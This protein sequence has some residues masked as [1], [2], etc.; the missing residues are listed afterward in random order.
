[1]D[2]LQALCTSG[3]RGM[4]HFKQSKDR[5]VQ[6][7]RQSQPSTLKIGQIICEKYGNNRLSTDNLGFFGGKLWMCSLTR[8]DCSFLVKCG[9]KKVNNLLFVWQLAPKWLHCFTVMVSPCEQRARKPGPRLAVGRALHRQRT[10]C[11]VM[12]TI[13]ASS[14]ALPE[15]RGKWSQGAIRPATNH[16]DLGI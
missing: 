8:N 3:L 2:G 7:L 13:K 5:P 16:L 11:E 12:V 6:C 10:W 4:V 15:T 14:K 9:K 1:M